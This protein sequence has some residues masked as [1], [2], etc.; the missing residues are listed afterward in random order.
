M[1]ISTE[2]SYRM[3]VLSIFVSGVKSIKDFL[4]FDIGF[5][6]VAVSK[7]NKRVICDC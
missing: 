2:T 5:Q 3:H 6:Q 1:H 4:L 7:H